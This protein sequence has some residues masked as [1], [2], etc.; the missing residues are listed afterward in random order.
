ML[1]S[2]LI[3]K[4]RKMV[5]EGKVAKGKLNAKSSKMLTKTSIIVAKC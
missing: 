2:N 5:N 3:A 4:S 1:K